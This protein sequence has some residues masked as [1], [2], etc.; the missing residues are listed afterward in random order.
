[1]KKSPRARQW[2]ITEYLELSTQYSSLR[3]L[4]SVRDSA[5]RQIIG[6]HF[7]ADPVADKNSNSVLAHFAGHGC[8]HH[9]LGVVELYFEECIGLLVNDGALRRNQIV[10]GQIV[11]PFEK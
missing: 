5:S 3:S 2:R 10:S 9:V 6:R 1:M 8:Q 11:S 4:V 7:N